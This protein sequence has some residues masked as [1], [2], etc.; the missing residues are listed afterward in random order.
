MT[1]LLSLRA[2]ILKT[3]RTAAFYFTLVGAAVV[4]V[5]YLINVMT[6]GIESTRKDPLNAIFKLLAEANGLAI[7][8][9]FVILACTLLPQ[10]EYRNNTWK[11][12]LT[13]PSTKATVYLSKFFNVQLLLLLF[14]VSTHLFMFVA[15]L[16]SHYI[17]PSLNLLSHTLNLQ[18]VLMKAANTFI[19]VQALCAIQFWIGVRFKNFIVPVA[20]GLTLWLAGT[21]LTLEIHSPKAVYFPYDFHIYGVYP[22]LA[23]QLPQVAWTSVGC[24][25]FFLLL[26]FLDF[27]RRRMNA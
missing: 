5:T 1:L 26:G 2:E 10:I 19:T 9:W 17:D 21:M 23:A 27:R 6:D 11:Q 15:I 3:R 13:S 12:V 7:F 4:P 18:T 24:A 16:A 25:I 20:F 14:L 22:V 8:P